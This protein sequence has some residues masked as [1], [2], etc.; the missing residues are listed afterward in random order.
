VISVSDRDEIPLNMEQNDDN[1]KQQNVK[2]LNEQQ[3]NSLFLLFIPVPHGELCICGPF[4]GAHPGISIYIKLKLSLEKKS[5]S[6]AGWSIK[7]TGLV[8]SLRSKEGWGMQQ[9]RHFHVYDQVYLKVSSDEEIFAF[10]E[11]DGS[12]ANNFLDVRICFL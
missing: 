5:Q 9:T 3:G 8:K 6:S 12:P 4:E 7:D 11:P 10:A 2:I 1:R